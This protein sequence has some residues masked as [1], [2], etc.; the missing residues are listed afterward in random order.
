[1]MGFVYGIR[2]HGEKQSINK[3]AFHQIKVTCKATSNFTCTE[4]RFVTC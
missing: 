1:M 2:M 4:P 3:N